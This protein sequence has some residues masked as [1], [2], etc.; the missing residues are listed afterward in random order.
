MGDFRAFQSIKKWHDD[1]VLTQQTDTEKLSFCHE[2]VLKTVFEITLTEMINEYG[3]PPSEFSWFVMGSAGRGE[4][5]VISDQDH[6]IIY[7]NDSDSKAKSYF[8]KLGERLVSALEY[9]GYPICD[10]NVMS[11]NPI[12]CQSIKDMETQIKQWINE[13]SWK[14]LRYLL[15]FIDARVLV[16]DGENLHSLKRVVYQAIE[17]DSS[18]IARLFENTSYNIKALGVYNQFLTVASGPYTGCIDLKTTAIFPYVNAVRLLAIIENLEVTSTL[19][20]LDSLCLLD[21]YKEELDIHRFHFQKLLDFR[22]LNADVKNYEDIRYLNVK[23]L[24]KYEKRQLKQIYKD[25]YKLQKFTK[26][27]AQGVMQ[28]E[29]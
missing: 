5:A 23:K 19:A 15:I 28:N 27:I 6:G 8:L 2:Y 9:I 24:N 10:G 17:K 29:R 3:S 22:L 20:R 13:N 7:K 21:R 14:S 11:S 1:N 26:K 16:G 25:L 12:W 4:Q 18:I